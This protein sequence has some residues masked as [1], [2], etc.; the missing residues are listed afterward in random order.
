[1]YG[2][3]PGA[4][5]FHVLQERSS[6]S[7]AIVFHVNS[8]L[9]FSSALVALVGGIANALREH[10]RLNQF[11]L[12]DGIA[13]RAHDSQA[14]ASVL[15]IRLHDD[16]SCDHG[17]IPAVVPLDVTRTQLDALCPALRSNIQQYL[18][19]VDT[20]QLCPLQDPRI[21]GIA[22]KT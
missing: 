8:P 1:M 10:A 16:P 20:I 18:I 14:R 6:A 4:T 12:C 2:A 13:L 11:Q 22:V 19:I 5:F 21:V 15:D 3:P 17:T 7:G 9:S